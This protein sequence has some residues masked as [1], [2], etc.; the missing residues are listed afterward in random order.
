MDR[1]NRVAI[2]CGKKNLEYQE[3]QAKCPEPKQLCQRTE[4]NTLQCEPKLSSSSRDLQSAN[5]NN[6]G[7]RMHCNVIQ[8]N[9]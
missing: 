9:C 1:T 5:Y 6:V 4:V 7:R 2:T 8:L 3:T